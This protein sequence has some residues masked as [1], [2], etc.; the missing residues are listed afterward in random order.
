MGIFDSLGRFEDAYQNPDVVAITF[1]LL[2]F[3]L[4]FMTL[5]KTRILGRGRAMKAVIA[6]GIAIYFLGYFREL[7]AWIAT[8][9]IVVYIVI[10][11]FLLLL[12]RPFIRKFFS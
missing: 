4:V 10:G 6:G 8:F 1:A 12:A 9:N 7:S 2:I 11:V 5:H 3:L